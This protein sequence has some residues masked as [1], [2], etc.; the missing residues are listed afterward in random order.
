MEL[1]PLRDFRFPLEGSYSFMSNSP[2]LDLG[3]V[4]LRLEGP[5]IGY[6]DRA[7][8]E[9]VPGLF[10]DN[11]NDPSWPETLRTGKKEY[12]VTLRYGFLP[13]VKER[14]VREVL[15]H[16]D[17]GKVAIYPVGLT[18]FDAPDYDVLVIELDTD[19]YYPDRGA[20]LRE[21][22]AQL[23]ILPNVNTFPAYR[24]HMTVGY[25]VK[26]SREF[27]ETHYRNSVAFSELE[28]GE[29]Y[30]SDNMKD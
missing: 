19:F 8:Q 28:A 21:I 4:M 6:L 14:H 26:G 24:A 1:K 3:C 7:S 16:I 22:N 13:G 23:G 5:M 15:D 20:S 27:L 2:Q 29:V 10:A 18:W 12:H 30:F 11:T 17:M 9:L 25:F